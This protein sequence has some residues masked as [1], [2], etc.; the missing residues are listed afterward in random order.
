[1]SATIAYRVPPVTRAGEAKPTFTQPPPPETL[2]TGTLVLASTVEPGA[3][4]AVLR[5]STLNGA[6]ARASRYRSTRSSLPVTAA[7]NVCARLSG[8]ELSGP[9]MTNP[10]ADLSV[11]L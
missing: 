7:V 4:P 8:L 9:S 1:V 3:P 2:A 11:W 5:I 6:D 10:P